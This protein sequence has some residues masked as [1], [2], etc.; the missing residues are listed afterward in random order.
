MGA[1]ILRRMLLIIPTLLGIM[2]LNFALVQFLPGGPIEQ[3]IA[4][5]ENSGDPLNRIGGDGSD[6]GI[7]TQ[8]GEESKYQAHE[9]T[10]RF[11]RETRSPIW[12]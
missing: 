8:S 2:V 5:L 10:A 7:I 6:A 3:V 11:H 9:T 4:Q 1:Y 12:L